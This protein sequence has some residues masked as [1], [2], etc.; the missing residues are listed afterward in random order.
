MSFL[1]VMASIFWFMLLVA[2]FWLMV[3]V[4]SDLFR[5]RDLSG[6]A[7][8]LWCI[9]VVLLPWLGVRVYLIARGRSMNERALRAAEQNE[10]DFRRYVRDVA[11]DRPSIA[12][13]LTRLADLRD[14]GKLSAADYELAK[15]QL[16]GALPA[17]TPVTDERPPQPTAGS[18][19]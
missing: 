5:D 16:L 9:F 12:G 3:T 18:A 14:R 8:A 10:Q 4:I 2:W 17:P 6:L 1:E 15:S 19:A 13:E 7:K 11:T